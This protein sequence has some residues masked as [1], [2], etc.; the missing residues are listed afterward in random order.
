MISRVLNDSVV[1]GFKAEF[2]DPNGTL[3]AFCKYAD[4]IVAAWKDGR[5]YIA[6]TGTILQASSTGKSRLIAQV[7]RERFLFFVCLRDQSEVAYPPRS[8][9]ADTIPD[10][11]KHFTSWALGLFV[12]CI[13]YL[14]EV[15]GA[16]PEM[17]P[18]EWM[19][20]QEDPAF[21]DKIHDNMEKF[22]EEN[23]F[24]AVSQTTSETDIVVPADLQDAG[25]SSD[26][27][28]ST[29]SHTD[30]CKPADFTLHT[31]SSKRRRD[32]CNLLVQA[33]IG[34]QKALERR[35]DP[36]NARLIFAFDEASRLIDRP[37][38]TGHV[39]TN[40]DRLR[41]V[42][43][44][45]P[46]CDTNGVMVVFTDT[47]MKV[48]DFVPAEEPKVVNSLRGF[49]AKKLFQPFWDLRFWDV[50]VAKPS[51][52]RIDQLIRSALQSAANTSSVESVMND[53]VLETAIWE[54]LRQLG[55]PVWSSLTKP[56]QIEVLINIALGKLCC[57]DFDWSLIF[58]SDT[59]K[60]TKPAYQ[61]AAATLF[62][63][64]IIGTAV[65]QTSDLTAR[66]M[67][68]CAHITPKC[69]RMTVTYPSDPVFA[70]AALTALKFVDEEN[71]G[72]K[73]GE[74]VD[75]SRWTKMAS[76]LFTSVKSGFMDTGDRG[77]LVA[78]F[79]LL[80]AMTKATWTAS[81][82]CYL[83]MPVT[84]V[85]F[86]KALFGEKRQPVRLADDKPDSSILW[87]EAVLDEELRDGLVFFNHFWYSPD[88]N[89]VET[90]ETAFNCC[91][92]IACKRGQRNVDLVIPVFLTKTAR[93][94]AILVQVKNW[95]KS[96]PPQSACDLG[97]RPSDFDYESVEDEPPHVALTMSLRQSSPGLFCLGKKNA[98]KSVLFSGGV[99]ELF[100]GEF[101]AVIG[102]IET[103]L[104]NV[105][106]DEKSGK[107]KVSFPDFLTL[108]V[109]ANGSDSSADWQ[110][111]III[112]QRKRHAEESPR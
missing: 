110:L 109:V 86:L 14:T 112:G 4:K 101:T 24:D 62:A 106:K 9:I 89:S 45:L 28:T 20:M 51:F 76:I 10:N 85:C 53:S 70:E 88:G 80:L 11:P 36:K 74:R 73:K 23:R 87:E 33:M 52:K 84:V 18:A 31:S 32:G 58:N 12:V 43:N 111:R 79:L 35:G 56:G 71:L 7:G 95:Q 39:T 92:A 59:H 78:R 25:S 91:A 66:F 97:F 49:D 40:L 65:Q 48:T 42:A 15:L 50:N 5:D 99:S 108:R 104:P 102:V 103:I 37:N 63:V 90:L 96:D 67:A 41:E 22:K 105:F 38:T 8:K 68:V 17:T 54:S 44:C 2:R 98:K 34:F 81:P 77:E 94:S 82:H 3:D 107:S 93:F 100:G 16:D 1:E 46:R 69:D 30:A 57:S 26:H 47:N 83:T 55:R 21:W 75:L 13:E 29:I 61:A 27:R 60:N 6:P 72:W 64:D 19:V